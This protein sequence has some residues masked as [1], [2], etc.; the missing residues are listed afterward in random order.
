[1]Y[2]GKFPVFFILHYISQTKRY[3]RVRFFQYRT[4]PHKTVSTPYPI[5][6]QRLDA[7]KAKKVSCVC[8][9]I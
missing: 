1:M 9:S 5:T 8:V 2:L 7:Q 4:A 6:V 3:R